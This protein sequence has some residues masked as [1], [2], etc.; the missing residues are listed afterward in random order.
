VFRLLFYLVFGYLIW[1]VIQIVVHSM[2]GPR[3]PH[4][5][6]STRPPARNKAETFKDIKDADFEELPP[7]EKK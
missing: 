6:T 1:K 4:D 7:D 5:E 2:S 3:R